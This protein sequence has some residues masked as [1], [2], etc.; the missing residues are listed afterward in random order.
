MDTTLTAALISASIAILVF[1]GAQAFQHAQQKHEYLKLKLEELYVFLEKIESEAW[2][3]VESR[4]SC[5]A[6]S[7]LLTSLR[8]RPRMLVRLYFQDLEKYL[9]RTETEMQ[10]VSFAM[11]EAAK[12][13]DFKI[14]H[15][16]LINS[17]TPKYSKL[18]D[19]LEIFRSHITAEYSNLTNSPKS[20]WI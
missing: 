13:K 8:E 2:I 10:I 11:V 6:Q 19:E 20:W 4:S 5:A 7:N 16:Y 1:I 12:K 18:C 17:F 15:E 3:R 14:D 9:K